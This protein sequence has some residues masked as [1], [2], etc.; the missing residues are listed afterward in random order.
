MTN[1]NRKSYSP[2]S[3]ES[4]CPSQK[5]QNSQSEINEKRRKNIKVEENRNSNIE[6]EVDHQKPYAST[7]QIMESSNAGIY[8][9]NFKMREAKRFSTADYGQP[10]EIAERQKIAHIKSVNFATKLVTVEGDNEEIGFIDEDGAANQ[11]NSGSHQRTDE[12]GRI[13]KSACSLLSPIEIDAALY[14]SYDH[15]RE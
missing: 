10:K 13:S 2:A 5:R 1:F 3:Y 7:T 4:F 11:E 8:I 12:D 6:T 9:S 14:L 15:M